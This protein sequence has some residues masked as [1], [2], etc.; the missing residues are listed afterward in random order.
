MQTHGL[1][2]RIDEFAKKKAQSHSG[3]LVEAARTAMHA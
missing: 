2:A 1:L 3:V